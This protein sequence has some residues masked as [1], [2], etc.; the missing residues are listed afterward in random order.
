[1]IKKYN[2]GRSSWEYGQKIPGEG[3]HIFL[4][5]CPQCGMPTFNYGGGWRCRNDYCYF[6][7]QNPI[8]NLGPEPKWW[9]TDI[10]V[11][12]DG[13]SWC[14]TRNGFINLQESLAGFGDSPRD[15]V[16]DLERQE[17]GGDK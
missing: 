9:K 2:T 8:G 6:N 3:W 16:A 7:A 13:K 10:N 11:F 12:L 4:G 14:A 15:A 5:P 1:M 17:G